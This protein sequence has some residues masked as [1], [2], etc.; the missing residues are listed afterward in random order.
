[1]RGQ[2]AKRQRSVTLDGRERGEHRRRDVRL[3][4]LAQ[5]PS[6]PLYSAEEMSGAW[7][8]AWWKAASDSASCLAI[9][10]SS[11]HWKLNTLG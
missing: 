1:M 5:A 3:G 8:P 2:L 4:L 10:G 11:L 9:G 6:E 7:N